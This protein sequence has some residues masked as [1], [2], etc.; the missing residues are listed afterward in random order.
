VFAKR[1]KSDPAV[2][3]I[4][5]HTRIRQVEARL[6]YVFGLGRWKRDKPTVLDHRSLSC[7]LIVLGST[8]N[9]I[10][11][12]RDRRLQLDNGT[13]NCALH[14][15]VGAFLADIAPLEF[16]IGD[17]DEQVAVDDTGKPVLSATIE[18]SAREHYREQIARLEA[19]L[20]PP[21]EHPATPWNTTPGPTRGRGRGLLSLAAAVLESAEQQPATPAPLRS[22]LGALGVRT[23]GRAHTAPVPQP[24][25]VAGADPTG[26]RTIEVDF[27]TVGPTR[28][29]WAA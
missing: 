27:A 17:E 10:G 7:S 28:R 15:G 3:T 9:A 13:K 6:N 2:A 20:G 8:Y 4:V 22:I 5:F 21:L 11:E 14:I 12:G 18:R 16:P 1:H 29:E 26:P 19:R 23:R 25:P 24:V